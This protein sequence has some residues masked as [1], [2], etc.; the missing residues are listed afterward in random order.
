MKIHQ[1]AQRA[2]F[3]TTLVMNT[4]GR[5][6]LFFLPFLL[7][8]KPAFQLLETYCLDCHDGETKKGNFDMEALLDKGPFDGTL[9]FENLITGKMPPA[10]KKQPTAAE[11]RSLLEW[12]AARQQEA[13]PAPFRRLSRHE[14]VHSVNDLLGIEFDISSDIPEDRGTYY[15]DTD[16]RIQLGQEML[17]KYF[18][19]ADRM[20]DFAFP[21]EGFLPEQTWVTNKL[22]DSHRTYNIYHRPYKEGTL[23]SWTRANNG[24]SYSF[25]WDN[26]DPPASGWYELTF[27]AAKVGKFEGDVSIQVHAG[28]YYYADDRPQPQRLLDVISVGSQEVKPYT[29]RVFLN[30]W[31]NVST[32][33][34]AKHN[35][36][37]RNPKTGAYIKQLK[38]RGPL[39]DQWPPKPYQ[40]VF[41]GLQIDAPDRNTLFH[42]EGYQSNLKK[43]GGK[44]TVSSFQEGMEKE[45]MQDGSN[46]TFWHTQFKPTLAKPPHFVIIENPNKVEINGLSYSTWTGGNGNGLVNQYEIYFS[47]D[48]K[49]WGNPIMDGGLDVRLSNTQPI[50]FPK[51]TNKPFIRFL[52]TGSKSLDGRSLASIGKLDV[53]TS[54]KKQTETTKVTI[55]SGSPKALKQVLRRFAETAFSSDLDD[56]A[57]APYFDIALQSLEDHGDFLR[58]AKAGL[59]SILC[60]PRFLMAPGEHSNPSYTKASSLAKTLWLSIPDQELLQLAQNNKLTRSALH[61]QIDR[62]L[63][64]G[65]SRR[66]VDSLCDQWLALGSWDKVT[67]SLKLYPL[68]DDLL[69]HYLP[70]ETK[71]YFQHLLLENL[72]V[73][74]LVDSNFSFLNQRLARHYGV[75]GVYGQKLRKVSFPS[76][77]PRGGL[78]TMGS[79]LK[80]TTDGFDT[81][82]ILRGAW[83]SKY[84]VGTPLSPPPEDVPVV[85]PDHSEA[86][87]LKEQIEQ[88]TTNKACFACHKDID[89]YGF[90]LENFD[91]SGQWREKYSVK[92][93]HR[94]T[95]TYRPQGYFRDA[96]MVDASS[97]IG[98]EQFKD[99]YGLKKILLNGHRKLAYNFAKKFFEYTNGY[100]PDLPQ[101]L[102][103]YDMTS[104]E[105]DHNR[106]KDLLSKVLV[107]SLEGAIE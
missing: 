47:E 16:R 54:T 38:V 44:V 37:N 62:M 57:L 21:E 75:D 1:E 19:V 10:E 20:L 96:G 82:P 84:I 71:A 33:S 91:A 90:A 94:G 70:L 69:N 92:L 12:L 49:S 52:I 26:F 60:S 53:L 48:G 100:A 98:R 18:S 68:Y 58:A 24:N 97:E 50:L 46:L 101:R 93:P 11:R 45:K 8:G 67:P 103:L 66:M 95:F 40:Q 23:F 85:E 42:S 25:F 63:I 2:P 27:D 65:K 87:T 43:I 6:S 80:I 9:M 59:K 83:I 36:R 35:F 79:I 104:E 102:E 77:V 86:T 34:F 28:K 39:Q 29:I 76:K 31:E 107:Y 22:M 5:L 74:H 105:P 99:I 61:A 106:M 73:T 3:L 64:D 7:H 72:S 15:F 88:H 81:S 56:S 51:P 14:F 13:A 17:T 4:L 32:H 89:P 55:S 41:S 30:P 78:L